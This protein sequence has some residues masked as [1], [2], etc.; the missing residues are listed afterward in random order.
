MKPRALVTIT[1]ALEILAKRGAAMERHW[2]AR[3]AAEG[4]IDG[5]VRVSSRLWLIPRAWAESYV[6][7]TRGRKRAGR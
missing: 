7:D 2:I 6:K 5:A 3:K 4:K 1:E